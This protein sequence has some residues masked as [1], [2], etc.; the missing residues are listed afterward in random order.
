MNNYC[1]NNIEAYINYNDDVD[2]DYIYDELREVELSEYI[3]ATEN[4]IECNKNKIK[5]YR[6]FLLSLVASTLLLM[7]TLVVKIF[8]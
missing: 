6:Y 2:Y 4:N 1:E 7:L 8:T 3:E 5:Y